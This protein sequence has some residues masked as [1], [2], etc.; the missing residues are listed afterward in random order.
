V[1]SQEIMVIL[2]WPY[3]LCQ[4]IRIHRGV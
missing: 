2:T 1:A 3:D 4:I